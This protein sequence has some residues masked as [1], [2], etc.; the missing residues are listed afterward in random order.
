MWEF[1]SAGWPPSNWFEK[2]I[3]DFVLGLLSPDIKTPRAAS[4]RVVGKGGGCGG[5]CELGRTTT[6][7][8]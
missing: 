7:L 8:F 2:D 1:C 5:Q 6:S 3:K 4:W